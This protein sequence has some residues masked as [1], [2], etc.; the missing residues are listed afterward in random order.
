MNDYPT[1]RLVEKYRAV[2]QTHGK[3][4]GVSTRNHK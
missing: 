3:I 1:D 4:D 2:G